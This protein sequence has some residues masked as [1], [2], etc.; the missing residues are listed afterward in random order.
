MK[1]AA[2][3]IL[4]VTLVMIFIVSLLVGSAMQQLVL[5]QSHLAR[6]KMRHQEFYQMERMALD[7]VAKWHPSACNAAEGDVQQTLEHGG[8]CLLE[9]GRDEYRYLIEDLGDFACMI[10]PVEGGYMASHQQRITL[11][12]VTSGHWLYLRFA[13]PIPPFECEGRFIAIRHGVLSWRF[14][15]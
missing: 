9:S 2:G 1:H 13:T 8:G 6:L 14:I 4:F 7:L 10:I 12:A 15:S 5:H 3:F 11:R